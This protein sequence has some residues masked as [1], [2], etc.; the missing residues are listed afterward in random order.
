MTKCLQIVY[1]H[2][3]EHGRVSHIRTKWLWSWTLTARSNNECPII[4]LQDKTIL[5]SGP[6]FSYLV[7]VF[8][9]SILCLVSK[10][11]KGHFLFMKTTVFLVL[12]LLVSKLNIEWILF[13]NFESTTPSLRSSTVY[14]VNFGE[15]C[16]I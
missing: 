13:V 8:L 16:I 10:E 11:R 7:C 4:Q 2:V 12:F 3:L 5:S 6:R 15:H 9:T 14:N 1:V